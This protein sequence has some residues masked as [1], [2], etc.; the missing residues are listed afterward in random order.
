MQLLK[1]SA[2]LPAPAESAALRSHS[3]ASWLSVLLDRLSLDG[4]ALLL[5]YGPAAGYGRGGG[6][7]PANSSNPT[8]NTSFMD[9][10]L[11]APGSD[12][13]LYL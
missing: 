7:H 6:A 8:K 12:L 4:G 10:S 9:L 5:S 2:R 13:F 11:S 3:D 1:A